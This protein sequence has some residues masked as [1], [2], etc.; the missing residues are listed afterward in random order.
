MQL[1]LTFVDG[2]YRRDILC[3]VDPRVTVG[4]LACHLTGA[5]TDA[6]RMPGLSCNGIKYPASTLVTESG[7]KNG[8]AVSLTPLPGHR[9]AVSTGLAVDVLTGPSAGETLHLPL[10]QSTL[11]ANPDNTVKLRALG[12]A[13]ANLQVS[14]EGTV[15][16]TPISGTFSIGGHPLTG[17]TAWRYYDV[18]TCANVRLQVRTGQFRKLVC[19]T[20]ENQAYWDIQRPPRIKPVVEELKL[21]IPQKPQEPRRLRIP[22]AMMFLPL[23]GAAVMV[24][25]TGSMRYA[26]FA[27]LSPLMMLGNWFSNK[28][29]GHDEYLKQLDLFEQRT[30]RIQQEKNQGVIAEASQLRELHPNPA[31]VLDWAHNFGARLWERRMVDDDAL[32]LRLGTGMI[33]SAIKVSDPEAPDH[34]REDH[35]FIPDAPVSFDLRTVG[36]LG[37]CG[38]QPTTRKLLTWLVM[39]LSALRSYQDVKLT[40]LAGSDSQAD[41]HWTAWLP[42]TKAD[43]GQGARHTVGYD[44]TT[45]AKRVSELV[46]IVAE[47]KAQKDS[48][49]TTHHPVLVVVMDGTLAMRGIPGV[50][51][52]LQDGPDVGVYTICHDIDRAKLPAEVKDLVVAAEDSTLSYAQVDEVAQS[53]IVADGISPVQAGSAA[54]KLAQ[55]RDTGQEE[56]SALPSSCRLVDLLN[57]ENIAPENLLNQWLANGCG[58][59]TSLGETMDGP[60]DLDLIKDG[61]HALVAGTTGSGKSELLQ[62]WVAGLASGYSTDEMNFVL[63]DY[64]GGAAFAECNGLPHTVGMVTDLDNHLVERCLTSLKAELHYRELVLAEVSCPD[65]GEYQKHR[66]EHPDAEPMPRLMIVIDEFA[67]LA[68]ELPDFVT[69]LIDVARR[70]RSLGIHL[71]LATQRPSGVVN[72][73][74]KSNMNL[75]IALRVNSAGDSSDVVDDTAAASISRNTPGRAVARLGHGVLIPFQTARVAQPVGSDSSA[76]QP[77]WSVPFDSVAFGQEEMR[78]PKSAGPE[79]RTETDLSHFVNTANKAHALSALP[80]P[81][82]PWLPALP[83]QLT[84]DE[85]YSRTG[86]SGSASGAIWGIRDVPEKQQ[87]VPLAFDLDNTNHVL[88]AGASKAGRTQALRTLGAALA[89]TYTPGDVH[90]YGIDCGNG[91]L[92][93]LEDLPHCGVVVRRNET[94]RATTLIGKLTDEVARRSAL[95]ARHRAANLSELRR[96]TSP[97][98]P[99]HLPYIVVMLDRY[100]NW[101]AVY[102]SLDAGRYE[103]ALLALLSDGPSVGLFGVLAGDRV[104]GT[105][106]VLA[107]TEE[108]WILNMHDDGDYSRFGIRT[109]AVPDNQVPGQAINSDG[110]QHVQIAL[111]ADNPDGSA[112]AAV[113]SQIA[114]HQK[115]VSKSLPDHHKPIQMRVLPTIVSYPECWDAATEPL[116]PLGIGGEDVTALGLNPETDPVLTICGLPKSGRSTMA[117]AA[118]IGFIRR[119]WQVG[120]MA[121]QQSALRSLEGHSS[122]LFVSK[123]SSL[124]PDFLEGHFAGTPKTALILD[125]AETYRRDPSGYWIDQFAASASDH[126]HAFVACGD[127]SA[128]AGLPSGWIGQLAKSQQAVYTSFSGRMDG[129]LIGMKLPASVVGVKPEPGKAWYGYSGSLQNLVTPLVNADG[130]TPP[131]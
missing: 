29:S 67:A 83:D 122:V 96:T 76:R 114:T 63:V 70:G 78:R 68:Q 56:D 87:Q 113:I 48:A 38:H 66:A 108:R 115:D 9:P 85:V 69:G 30:A 100:E 52:L 13:T 11:G 16:I 118:A 3:D 130:A 6:D 34:R 75:R 15:T 84:L 110:S 94:E 49:H 14:L 124:D 117:L 112:Q 101:Q 21:Q 35:P 82:K 37:V 73:E 23:I 41:W 20:S 50:L 128:L 5:V 53:G 105:S 18:L 126:Q 4:E 129:D 42:H 46:N 86:G 104:L 97:D 106:K 79:R 1:A 74:I 62:S 116:I 72:A 60:L 24:T 40:I 10:G 59:T 131:E 7:I 77:S 111:L 92:L 8:S 65:L 57:L 90:L 61:P 93:P 103:E 47:R 22:V 27:L 91:G 98:D 25:V 44:S 107:L 31:E 26:I 45:V 54:R 12:D 109:N 36:V 39:Q 80:L 32:V 17:P 58:A 121:P 71:V 2:A 28:Q 102:G 81:R 127:V 123:E 99:D 33:A 119:G 120:I 125:D 89:M 43:L 95:L 19:K 55:L 51:A 64:K 88:I